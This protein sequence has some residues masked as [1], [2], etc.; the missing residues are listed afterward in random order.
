MPTAPYNLRPDQQR[1][2]ALL[3]HPLILN[4]PPSWRRSK[5]EFVLEY[6]FW[7]EP[8]PR[9][10]GMKLGTKGRCFVNAFR[11]AQ[12]NPSLVY[13]EGFCLSAGGSLL[14][15]HGWATDGTG[16]VIDNTLRKAAAAY[17]GVPFGTEFLNAN[18]LKN[19]AV[20]CL[21]DDYLHDWPMLG[22][23]GDKPELW[24]EAKGLGVAR[25][26]VP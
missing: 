26:V 20:I 22:E 18:L 3:Q 15:H 10:K 14:I 17:A 19:R 13:C 8:A 25:L 4:R 2:L 21:L 6:G 24:L 1:L 12:D 23:L 11:L 16:R 9:P 5:Y 7:Y